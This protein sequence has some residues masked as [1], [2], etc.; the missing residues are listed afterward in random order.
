MKM[1]K[2]SQWYSSV[3]SF[4]LCLLCLKLKIPPLLYFGNDQYEGSVLVSFAAVYISQ[5]VLEWNR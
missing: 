1:T 4:S 5:E 3:I 2:S